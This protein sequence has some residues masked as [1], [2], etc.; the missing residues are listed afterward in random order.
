MISK[1]ISTS[2]K[3]NRLEDLGKV[4]YT[5]FIPHCDDYGHMDG[6]AATVKAIVAPLVDCSLEAVERQLAAMETLGLIA[7]Y[8]VAGEVYL[9]ISNF[10]E[11]QTFKSDR[12]KWE[13]S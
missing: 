10:E 2:K 3:V 6:D 9:E 8:Q 7:R 11:F 5:W 12:P 1:S 13:L 4:L